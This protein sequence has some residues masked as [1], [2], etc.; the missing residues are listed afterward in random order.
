ML[1]CDY[2]FVYM[3]MVGE[4]VRALCRALPHPCAVRSFVRASRCGIVPRRELGV[5]TLFIA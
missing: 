4:G 2:S 5:S 3:H 1:T